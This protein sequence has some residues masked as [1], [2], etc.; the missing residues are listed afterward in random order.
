MASRFG[1]KQ[2]TEETG[3]LLSK[4]LPHDDSVHTPVSMYNYAVETGDMVLQE[5]CLQYL[6]WNFERLAGSPAWGNL[7]VKLLGSIL[8]RSDLVVGDEFSLLLTVERWITK[9]NS[10]IS[11]EDQITLLSHIRFPMIPVEELNQLKS[12][13]VLYS[14]FKQMYQE[15]MLMAFQFNSLLFSNLEF[16]K[17]DDFQPIYYLPRIY[18]QTPW[19]FSVSSIASLTVSWCG[20]PRRTSGQTFSTPIHNSLMSAD[21]INWKV[22]AFTKLDHCLKLGVTCTSLPMARLFPQSS[23]TQRN[24]SFRNH[25]LLVCRSTYVSQVQEFK[26]N[27]VYIASNDTQ[28]AYPCPNNKYTYYF[29][30]SPVYVV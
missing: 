25:L 27:I 30:V 13:S 20:T 1:V 23:I 19:S 18:K 24:L 16:N 9:K 3:R 10:S 28:L 2:L 26:D 8:R 14:T 5:N 12:R 29:V 21:K 15:K 11:L 6:A 4:V 7:S 17:P 22:Y